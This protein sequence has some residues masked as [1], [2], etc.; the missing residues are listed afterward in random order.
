M[1]RSYWQDTE[2]VTFLSLGFPYLP[3]TE[4]KSYPLQM[5]AL[6]EEKRQLLL[7][8]PI[9]T[10]TQAAGIGALYTLLARILPEMRESEPCRS[11]RIV[12]L[13]EQLLFENIALRPSELARAAGVCESAL[14][15]AFEKIGEE[16]PHG[17][18]TRILFE[19]ARELLLTTDLP[20]EHIADRLGF[21]SCTSFRKKFKENYGIAP[22]E[23]RKTGAV[24]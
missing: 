24:L 4:Q 16:T 1:Y 3:C 8:V 23:M 22:R 19:K 15:A 2:D 6:N 9:G 18:R 12:A 20:I 11:R 17:M 5:L 7:S 10:R 21:C 13:C 14:Y